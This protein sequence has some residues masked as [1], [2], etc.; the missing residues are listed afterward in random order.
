MAGRMAYFTR[1]PFRA[2]VRAGGA[3]ALC[4]SGVAFSGPAL[5]AKPAPVPL[6]PVATYADLADLA[7]SS[8]LILQAEI[9][10]AVAVEAARAPGLR[11]GW[12]RFY[13]EA[14]TRALLFG[15]NTVGESLRYL[16]DVPLDSRGKPPALRKKQVLLFA[17]GVAGRPGELQLV[18]PD[19]QLPWDAAIEG[20]LRGV[21]AELLAPGAPGR[22]SGVREAIH[23][24]GTLAGAGETQVFLATPDG[25]PASITVLRRPDAPPAWSASFTEVLESAANAP[26]RETLAWYRLACF[27]PPKLPSA[28]NVSETGGDRQQA[29][30]DY[31]LVMQQLGA[32]PRLRR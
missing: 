1:R 2:L 16:V 10:K 8:P 18:A 21:I 3:A 4:L 31:D 27:L 6:A 26:L 29:M 30:L 17:R 5:A 28:A 32:C 11:A 25:A 9:R 13:I 15:A 24:S 12:G 22:I 19:A 7:D 23:V 20:R 14:K